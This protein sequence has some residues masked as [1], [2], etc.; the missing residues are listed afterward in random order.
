M[1][2][3]FADKQPGRVRKK[4]A[5]ETYQNGE[6]DL[7]GKWESPSYTALCKGKPQGEPIRNCEASDAIGL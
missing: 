4:R 5:Q 7:E 2:L 3:S 6:K 1:M